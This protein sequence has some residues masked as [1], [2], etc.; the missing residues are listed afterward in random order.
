M[1]TADRQTLLQQLRGI[2][3]PPI[4][5]G[6]GEL[7]RALLPSPS[8][9]PSREDD[10]DL[11]GRLHAAVAACCDA[12]RLDAGKAVPTLSADP[13]ESEAA[14]DFLDFASSSPLLRLT[15]SGIPD[16]VLPAG[17]AEASLAD[18]KV[19]PSRYESDDTLYCS[20]PEI[21]Q[22][23]A[24]GNSVLKVTY[25]DGRCESR[26]VLQ[27][28]RKF[29]GSLGDE[30]DDLKTAEEGQHAGNAAARGDK[31]AKPAVAPAAQSAL[32]WKQFF[33]QPTSNVTSAVVMAKANGEAAHLSAL[34]FG[35][36]CLHWM[37]REEGG[38]SRRLLRDIQGLPN[39][40]ENK[41]SRPLRRRSRP[42]R[43]SSRTAT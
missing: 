6:H 9:C 19:S 43:R 8:L 39:T 25:D 18:V 33:L 37:G 4:H 3:P 5:S 30:D 12:G 42:L 14:E 11:Q 20:Q 27:S 24:R 38:G 1:A 28:F 29:T 32:R 13:R 7:F 35:V 40:Q 22:R 2:R 31:K 15:W 34:R 17:V 26:M 41:R 36:S 10:E 21:R 23:V 16:R